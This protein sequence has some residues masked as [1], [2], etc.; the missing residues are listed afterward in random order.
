[1][2]QAEGFCRSLLI[3]QTARTNIVTQ[4]VKKSSEVKIPTG[5]YV[6]CSHCITN[7]FKSFLHTRM[8][9]TRRK[10]RESTIKHLLKVLLFFNRTKRADRS[11]HTLVTKSNSHSCCTLPCYISSVDFTPCRKPITYSISPPNLSKVLSHV[12]DRR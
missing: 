7:V 12:K 6:N 1:M 10:E 9:S 8:E 4:G 5:H 3:L 11:V 2:Y